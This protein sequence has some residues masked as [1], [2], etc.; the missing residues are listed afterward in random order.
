MKSNFDVFSLAELGGRED[1]TVDGLTVSPNEEIPSGVID[2]YLAEQERLRGLRME[3]ARKGMDDW[4][5]ALD[6]LYGSDMSGMLISPNRNLLQ[7][8]LMSSG[9]VS[10]QI[11]QTEILIERTVEQMEK[12]M[13]FIEKSMVKEKDGK[14]HYTVENLN[15]ARVATGAPLRGLVSIPRDIMLTGMGNDDENL[16]IVGRPPLRE[17][18]LAVKSQQ[19]PNLKREQIIENLMERA[20]ADMEKWAHGT[21]LLTLADMTR[22]VSNLKQLQDYFAAELEEMTSFGNIIKGMQEKGY[23]MDDIKRVIESYQFRERRE[24]FLKAC[25]HMERML[26]L[27]TERMKLNRINNGVLAEEINDEMLMGMLR[28]A[29]TRRMEFGAVLGKEAIS[30]NEVVIKEAIRLRR[31]KG[32]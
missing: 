12:A 1:I 15:T 8:L 30:G 3:P 6:R 22:L 9:K 4:K 29:R 21:Q 32:R 25:R 26:D 7:E 27:I 13:Q 17:M 31:S 5:T 24:A 20:T 19:I 16:L 11:L 18:F 14:P 10:T 23:G 2:I 28:N